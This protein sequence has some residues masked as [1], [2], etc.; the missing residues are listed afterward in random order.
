MIEF[1]ELQ[2]VYD[3]LGMSLEV[4]LQNLYQTKL[5]S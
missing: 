5:S 2:Y 3:I 1:A 4:S